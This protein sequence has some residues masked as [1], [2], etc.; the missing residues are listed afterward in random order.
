MS[1]KANIGGIPVV[2]AQA[3]PTPG[4]ENA[5]ENNPS[6]NDVTMAEADIS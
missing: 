2:V 4:G 6:S 3:S 1:G 5:S